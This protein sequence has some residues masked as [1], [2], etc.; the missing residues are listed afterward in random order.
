MAGKKNSNI[1]M[2]IGQLKIGL[3]IIS[4]SIFFDFYLY[5]YF[6]RPLRLWYNMNFWMKDSLNSIINTIKNK[7][8]PLKWFNLNRNYPNS[9]ITCFQCNFDFYC[10]R[11]IP[12]SLQNT[13]LSKSMLYFT[14]LGAVNNQKNNNNIDNVQTINSFNSNLFCCSIST[15][16]LIENAV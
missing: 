4:Q 2:T 8:S 14:F 3:A 11:S 5:L 1:C 7:N 16:W 13:L 10:Y 15:N 12:M 6:S 9:W